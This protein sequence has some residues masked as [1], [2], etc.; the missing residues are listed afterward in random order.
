MGRLTSSFSSSHTTR[1]QDTLAEQR[2][3]QHQARLRVLESLDCLRN[4]PP[5]EL[6]CLVDLCYFR[7]FVEGETIIHER[8]PGEFLYLLLDGNVRLT[9]QDR[10]KKDILLDVLGRG[11][12][13]GESALFNGSYRHAGAYAE[14]ICYALQFPVAE[15]RSLLARCPNLHDSLRHVH[16]RRMVEGTLAHG[17]LFNDISPVERMTLA[18][19]MQPTHYA[20]GHIIMQCGETSNAL[21]VIESGQA[22]VEQDGKLIAFLDEGDFFGEIALYC[23]QYHSATVRALTP[24]DILALSAERFHDLLQQ[25]PELDARLRRVIE[26]RLAADQKKAADSSYVEH[27]REIIA[28]GLVRGTHLLVRT[29]ALCPP[30]CARCEEGCAV[31]FGQKRLHLNGMIHGDHDILDSCRQCRV[32]TEC[33]EACPYDAFRWSE[34]GVLIITD[35]CTGCGECIPACPYDAITRVPTV[36]GN[37]L[38]RFMKQAGQKLRQMYLASG[39][40]DSS[41]RATYPYRAD[42]CDLCNG[43]ADMAC[44]AACPVGSLHLLPVEEV[45]ATFS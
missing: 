29:P 4:V 39:W 13:V 37:N 41:F 28:H 44:V 1:H 6:E 38:I 5:G 36:Q 8:K 32:G 43:Y 2:M 18:D 27:L 9:I 15:V 26:Q 31:R 17:S 12:C 24:V 14:T 35:A 30:G 33:V 11:D 45:L 23:Q 10:E 20:R 42:K 40:M 34:K 25:H 3:Q 22:V 21:Y 7:A 16:L 19:L